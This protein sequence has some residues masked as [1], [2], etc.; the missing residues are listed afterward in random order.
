[1]TA[2]EKSKLIKQS[3]K[4]YTYGLTVENTRFAA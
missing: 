4:L 3:G 2:K 1:M